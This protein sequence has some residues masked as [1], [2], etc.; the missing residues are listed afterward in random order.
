M[1]IERLNPAGLM[2]PEGYSHVSVAPNGRAVHIAGQ[3]ALDADGRLIADDLTGQTAAALQNVAI[4]LASAGATFEDVVAITMLVVDWEPA[5]H[6][7]LLDG[8]MRAA[9]D[10]GAAVAPTTLI[11]V[12][13]LFADGL[14]IEITMQAVI[15]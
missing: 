4:A 14:L 7:Q 9:A 6:E 3:T 5:K 10:H 15:V 11:P 8:V 1:I 13:R 12:P 2:T